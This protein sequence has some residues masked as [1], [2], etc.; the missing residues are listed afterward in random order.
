MS[1]WLMMARSLPVGGQ[2]Y[3][4]LQCAINTLQYICLFV[5]TKEAV[6]AD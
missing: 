1:L 2:V 5:T 4:F 3:S 6:W